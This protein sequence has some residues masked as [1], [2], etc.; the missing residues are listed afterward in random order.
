M[1]HEQMINK[2]LQL[3]RLA[4]LVD[5]EFVL[6]NK[7]ERIVLGVICEFLVDMRSNVCSID[8]PDGNAAPLAGLF[9]VR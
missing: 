8:N 4:F 5:P 1:L 2:E 9:Q 7:R 3:I 6:G